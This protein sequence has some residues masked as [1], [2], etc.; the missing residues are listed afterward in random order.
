ML[1]SQPDVPRPPEANQGVVYSTVLPQS[2]PPEEEQAQQPNAKSHSMSTHTTTVPDKG[3][4]SSA[5]ALFIC[6]NVMLTLC[7]V[8][9]SS[10]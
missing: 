7:A 8:C 1:N 4:V 3:N 5:L 6:S 2:F 10:A 9:S